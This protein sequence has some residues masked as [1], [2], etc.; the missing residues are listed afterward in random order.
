MIQTIKNTTKE[1]VQSGEFD[2]WSA[3]IHACRSHNE[4]E[5]IEGYAPFQWAFGRMPTLS[6]SFHNKSHDLPFWTSSGIPG[7]SMAVN[8][9]QRVKAQ[10]V[11]MRHQA[12]D[13]ITRAANAKT[14]RHQVFLP[15]DL[16]FFKR[17]KPPAQPQAA[18]RR[19]SYGDGTDLPESLP[20]RRGQMPK[21]LNV[22]LPTL[23]GLCLMVDSSDVLLS[24]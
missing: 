8:L 14:R 15:G 12:F 3:I 4:G 20:V 19:T 22:S 16:V 17:I 11:F 7:S 6:G 10:N 1:L 9:K 2:A 18:A 5:R 23:C 21:E 13:Q 24:S